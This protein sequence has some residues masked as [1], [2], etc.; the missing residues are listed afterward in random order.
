MALDPV[1]CMALAL[2]LGWVMAEAGLHKLREPLRF[3][4]IIDAYRLLP[5]G[6]GAR[7]AWPLGAL[8]LLA[9][10]ALLVP[11]TQA[12]AASLVVALL[13][14]YAL[15]IGIN[16]AR[17]RR[18]IDCG[19]GGVAQPLSWTLIV[20]NALLVS[21][22]GWLA[23]GT[24]VQRATGWLDVLVAVAAAVVAILCYA[25]AAQLGANRQRMVRAR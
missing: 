7:I 22:A 10:C 12:G 8:E 20:R 9:G 13:A 19:C 15:A 24:P 23:T 17:G 4:G 25:A 11:F 14:F 21:L 1:V 18:D 6:F 5:G 16:L 3:G 2:L